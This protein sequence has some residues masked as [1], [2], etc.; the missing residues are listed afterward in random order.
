MR[1]KALLP[2]LVMATPLASQTIDLR[3]CPLDRLD[4]V[5]TDGVEVFTVAQVGVQQFA[6]CGNPQTVVD[7][8]EMEQREDCR[9]P[10]GHVILDGLLHDGAPD[11]SATGVM[12]IWSVLP[13]EPCCG[14]SFD[15]GENVVNVLV[16]PGLPTP[17]EAFAA[18]DWLEPGQV[19]SLGEIDA[20]PVIDRDQGVIAQPTLLVPLICR[21]ASG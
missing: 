14:W 9:G 3:D 13:A 11:E 12:A 1:L 5:D 19:P 4:F 16:G 7:L 8:S 21:P 2:L 20:T 6:I 15:M 10:F 17:N 18:I